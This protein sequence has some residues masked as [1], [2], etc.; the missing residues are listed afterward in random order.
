MSDNSSKNLESQGQLDGNIAKKQIST[1][2]K[3]DF[4]FVKSNPSKRKNSVSNSQRSRKRQKLH[5]YPRQ[6]FQRRGPNRNFRNNRGRS[7]GK[8]RRQNNRPMSPQM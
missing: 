2:I 8:G 5:Q 4:S 6:D 3:K 1:I 7:R